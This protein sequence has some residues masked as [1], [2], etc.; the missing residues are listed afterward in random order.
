MES[1]WSIDFKLSARK[2]FLQ[3]DDRAKAEAKKA[4]ADLAEDPFPE[5][6]VELRGHP[7]LYRIRFYRDRYRIVYSVSEKQRK[8]FV[9]RVRPR[10]SAYHGLSSR[11]ES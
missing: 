7:G 11:R 4:I 8:V 6:S 2:E 3:L 9:Q 5:G 1:A 10:G